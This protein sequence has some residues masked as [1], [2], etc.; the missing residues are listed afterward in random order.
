VNPEDFY[1]ILQAF[2]FGRPTGLPLPGE[3]AGILS[4]PA[5]W[6]L[7]TKATIAFGQEISVSAL[8]MLQAATAIANGGL[9][10]TPHIVRKIVSASG[11]PVKEFNREPVREVLSPETARAVLDMMAAATEE[12]GTARRG[13]VEGVRI[14]A[15]TGTAQVLDPATSTYSQSNF[16]ASFL[17]I[18]P[19]EDPRLIVYV[20]INNPKGDAYYGSQI[21]AP[22][23]RGVAE[24]LIDYLGIRRSGDAVVEQPG[25]VRVRLPPPL[26]LGEA[27]PDLTGTPKRLLLP[28]LADGR[29]QVRIQGDGY[30]A[31]Q[32]P[33]P[34]TVL[35]PGT[36]ITLRLQ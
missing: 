9:M 16:I 28:L 29:L 21:A 25:S 18:F 4:A 31:A 33:A 10:L 32:D 12:G 15:K 34:G 26:R 5:R 17:G 27:M 11:E 13:R 2:G 14:S 7:R 24:D 19:T 3:S 23:F 36:I 35:Q 20:V 22:V 1:R 6:S 30:V 8:Q